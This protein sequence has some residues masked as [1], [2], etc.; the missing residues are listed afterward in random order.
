MSIAAFDGIEANNLHPATY[1]GLAVGD[2][3]RFVKGVADDVQP[4]QVAVIVALDSHDLYPVTV[5]VQKPAGQDIKSLPVA[6]DE[7]EVAK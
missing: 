3:V 4:G 6:L 7:I 5:N 1:E 2:K